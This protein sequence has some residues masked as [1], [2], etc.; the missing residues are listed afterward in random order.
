MKVLENG[1]ES[2]ARATVSQADGSHSR[3]HRA[4]VDVA[5]W[6]VPSR[7]RLSSPLEVTAVNQ[8]A[9]ASR[10]YRFDPAAI[11]GVEVKVEMRPSVRCVM[12]ACRVP[13][14][15]DPA[16]RE[17]GGGVYWNIEDAL[18]IAEALVSSVRAIPVQIEAT[19]HRVRD[20]GKPLQRVRRHLC[21]DSE[22]CPTTIHSHKAP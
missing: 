3:H 1:I 13:V 19:T 16:K 20:R 22:R 2:S 17:P 18:L 12:V 15:L 5:S 9:A 6:D 10:C 14:Y 4:H 21:P 11:A 7:N 8:L